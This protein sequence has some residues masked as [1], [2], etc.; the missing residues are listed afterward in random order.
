MKHI[1]T[2]TLFTLLVCS[3]YAQDSKGFKRNRI[4]S[5]LYFAMKVRSVDALRYG[6]GGVLGYERILGERGAL[7]VSTS[8]YVD[9]YSGLSILRDPGSTGVRMDVRLYPGGEGRGLYFGA[10]L[11]ANNQF[12]FTPDVTFGWQFR[13]SE[14][15]GLWIGTGIGMSNEMVF[16]MKM[17]QVGVNFAF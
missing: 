2:I 16:I 1:L 7:G 17:T 5:N 11:G 14:M 3:A 8:V 4:E 12:V 10:G 9:Y 6:G 13:L 15:V